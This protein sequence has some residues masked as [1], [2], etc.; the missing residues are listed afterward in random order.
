MTG[1]PSLDRDIPVL[2]TKVGMYPQHH[3]GLG[4]VR[5]IGRLGIPV[6]AIVEDRF[7]PVAVSRYVNRRFVWPT[8]GLEEPGRLV[9]GLLSIGRALATPCIPVATDDE[10]AILLAEESKQLSQWFL[11]PVIPRDLPRR[12]ANKADLH[13][14]CEEHGIPSPASRVAHDREELLA[15]ARE[16]GFPVVLKNLEAWSR[17]RT[18]AV[19]AT[20]LIHDELELVARFPTGELPPVL[21]QEYIPRRVAEDWFTHLYCGAGGAPV[22]T[23]TGLKLRSWPPGGGVTTRA[24]AL[25]NLPL[26]KLAAGLCRRIGYSGLADLDWRYD[27]RDGQYKLVDFNPRIGAQFRLFETIHRIDVVRAMYLDLTGRDIP[28]GPQ[29]EG[30]TFV[31]GHLDLASAGARLLEEHRLPPRLS[32]TRRMERSWISADDPLPAACEAVRFAGTVARRAARY[33]RGRSDRR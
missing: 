33:V 28:V 20:T 3:G 5:T 12:L 24:V 31:A 7:T 30:R 27:D 11:I 29:A 25:R 23:F 21:V 1:P 6:H 15:A 32:G 14:T 16:L 17:L 4:V 13:R 10:A 8:T 22:V 18:P 26:A 19:G 2:L 9:D